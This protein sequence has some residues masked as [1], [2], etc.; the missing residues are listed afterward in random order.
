MEPLYFGTSGLAGYTIRPV[1]I[2]LVALAFGVIAWLTDHRQLAIL[3]LGVVFLV[4]A[5]LR[6]LPLGNL[7]LCSLERKYP[8]NPNFT[9]VKGIITLGGGREFSRCWLVTHRTLSGR[10]QKCT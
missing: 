9:E 7:A 3:I 5:A 1:S 2:L 4:C 8:T 10:S 6:F